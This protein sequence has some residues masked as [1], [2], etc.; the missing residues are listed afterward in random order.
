MATCNNNSS[1]G[2]LSAA[3]AATIAKTNKAVYREISLLQ[4]AILD[5]LSGCSTTTG[6]HTK[7]LCITVAGTTPM[8]FFSTITS[9]TVTEPGSGYFDVIATAEASDITGIDATFDVNV[10]DE[11]VITS[12]DV[13]TPG[14]GYSVD[15]TISVIHPH[16]TGFTGNLLIIDG[17]VVGVEVVTGGINYGVVLPVVELQNIGNGS[18]ASL[19]ITIGASGEITDITVTDPGFNY[20]QDT[21]AV[22]VPAAVGIGSGAEIALTVSVSPMPEVD[23]NQYFLYLDDQT[24]TCN[25]ASD[26]SQVITYFRNK[27]YFIEAKIN[28]ITGSTMLWEICWC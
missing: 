20:S 27:G 23:A 15:A 4:E 14:S 19:E 16:G 10:S 3:Q 22:I 1:G 26:I 8:T 5:A 11:G 24:N 18:N 6:C 17:A 2:F 28:P 9:A 12:I 25:V 13:I 21:V 7:Q